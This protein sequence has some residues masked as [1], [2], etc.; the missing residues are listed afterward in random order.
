[1][2]PACRPRV[3]LSLHATRTTL[4]ALRRGETACAVAAPAG[5]ENRR[6]A[7]PEQSSSNCLPGKGGFGGY[8]AEDLLSSTFKAFLALD[9]SARQEGGL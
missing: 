1:M 3:I 5:T 8:P 6:W 2:T 9:P 4:A 7:K